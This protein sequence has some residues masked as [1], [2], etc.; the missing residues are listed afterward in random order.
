[1]QPFVAEITFP[2][3]HAQVA[4]RILLPLFDSHRICRERTYGYLALQRPI[5]FTQWHD[6]L[7]T[8]IPGPRSMLLG[9]RTLHMSEARATRLPCCGN[10]E[11]PV[12]HDIYLRRAVCHDPSFIEERL[13]KI[14]AIAFLTRYWPEDSVTQWHATRGIIGFLLRSEGWSIDGIMQFIDALCRATQDFRFSQYQIQLEQ[15]EQQIAINH[16]QVPGSRTLRRVFSH[17]GPQ[18]IGTLNQWL[19]LKSRTFS[20]K[21]EITARDWENLHQ[22]AEAPV[23]LRLSL[24]RR[25]RLGII[26]DVYDHYTDAQAIEMLID[27]EYARLEQSG[28]PLL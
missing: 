24:E 26:S 16:A 10:C 22:P 9:I 25:H 2:V 17:R 8:E 27:K 13:R 11:I 5:Y 21:G 18:V 1:M 23:L 6:P 4:A 28:C 19:L 3:L 15:M 20:S 12:G 14:S 7:A